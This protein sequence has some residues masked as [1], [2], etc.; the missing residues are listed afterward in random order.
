MARTASVCSASLLHAPGILPSASATRMQPPTPP[1]LHTCAP[2]T[3]ARTHTRALTHTHAHAHTHTH[4]HTH[5]VNLAYPVLQA[6]GSL[7]RRMGEVALGSEDKPGV[8][9][10]MA[11]AAVAFVKAPLKVCACTLASYHSSAIV[12]QAPAQ[13]CTGLCMQLRECCSRCTRDP[14]AGWRLGRLHSLCR[15]GEVGS[16]RGRGVRSRSLAGTPPQCRHTA[17]QP[18]SSSNM[19]SGSNTPR[20]WAFLR[21]LRLGRYGVPGPGGS[22]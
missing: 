17:I 18:T 1:P 21:S 8:G 2:R 7:A 4:T 20:S 13:P 16:S 10:K 9:R 15:L 5:R 14:S 11:G 6:V 12:L 22:M 3:C 19:G